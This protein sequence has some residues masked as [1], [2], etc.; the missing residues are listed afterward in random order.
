MKATFEVTPVQ[1]PEQCQLQE[2]A[3][4]I[5]RGMR[6]LGSLQLGGPIAKST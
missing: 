4:S 6:K 5:K 1:Q 3:L 2:F